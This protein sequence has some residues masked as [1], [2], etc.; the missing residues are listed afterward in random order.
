[1]WLIECPWNDQ[2]LVR[3]L[4]S[5][6]GRIVLLCDSG[7]EVWFH[8]DDIGSERIHY[9]SDPDWRAGC[10]S[11][12]PGTTRWATEDDIDGLGWDVEWRTF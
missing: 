10:E 1:M 4:V 6:S 9:P 2:G 11:I 7:G 3:P 5:T 8:P 12:Q